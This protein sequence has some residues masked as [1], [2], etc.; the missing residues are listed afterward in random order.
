MSAAKEVTATFDLEKTGLGVEP[1]K[2]SLK[3]TG[4]GKAFIAEG[5]S[6]YRGSPEIKC[7]YASPGPQT[8][9]CETKMSDEGEGW[10]QVFITVKAEPGSKF[11]GWVVKNT[12]FEGCT[13]TFATCAP[14]VEPPGT[15]SGE[16][17]VIATF[18][19]EPPKFKLTV[20]KQGTGSGTVTSSPAGI[21]CGA[22]CSAEFEEGT[23]VTL[24]GSPAAGSK[25][26]SWSGCGSV[27]GENKCLVTMS[28][29]KEVTATFD[30]EGPITPTALTIAKTG[31]GTITSSPAG[32]ECT[33][34]KTGAECEAKFEVNETV[35]LT[36]SPATGYA[37]G[38]WAGCTEHV[39]L[40]CKVLMDKAKT[41]K[42]SFIATPSLTVEKT[43]TG[44]GKASATGIACDEN[45]SKA[46]SAIKAGTV[47]TFKTISAK[48]SEAASF[49]G[50]TGSASGCSGAT[51]TFTI[52][53]NSS[54]K[55]KFNAA[56]T[57]TLTV[58][59]TGPAKYKGKVTGKGTA[60]GLTASAINCGSGCTTQTES[61]FA[62]DTVT[63]TAVAGTGYTFG[64]WSGSEAGTCTGKTSP[65]T[66]STSA[67]KTLSAKFE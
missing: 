54:V 26:V 51:C 46:T 9:V 23:T 44:Q 16:A 17:E 47:V 48:G 42:T 19:L 40:T 33:G 25:P 66:I 39:G 8:G 36:A 55:V 4:A 10:E 32:I 6:Q 60:K 31:E 24:A 63:L 52:S 14:F 18:D 62:S 34:A 37:F 12:E 58:N 43:G 41:V 50:G 57:K 64:G 38:A 53:E 49:E 67:N 22:T 27:N 59:L 11:V 2:V 15:G 21:S 61:F 3:G 30:L 7:A 1:V 5:G 28:A 65:C 56:P 35:T 20:K 45:C 13:G 29:A